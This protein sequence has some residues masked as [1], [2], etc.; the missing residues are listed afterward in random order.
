MRQ[1]PEEKALLDA[2]LGALVATLPAQVVV[3]LVRGPGP[4]VVRVGTQAVFGL[5]VR[6]GWRGQ[7]GDLQLAGDEQVL[8]VPYVGESQGE[9]LRTRGICYLDRVGNAWLTD[10]AG[11]LAVLVQ[12]RA[13]P[14][15]TAS[16]VG[17]LLLGKPGLRLVHALL[18]EPELVRA[19]Y[20]T[21]AAR[22]GLPV[23]TIGRAMLALHGQGFVR[24][25]T[26]RWLARPDELR[27]RWIDAYGETL[28]P[29]LAAGRYRWLE[30]ARA[31][32]GWQEVALP[33][34][35]RWGGETAAHLLLDGYL[36]P[37]YFTLYSTARRGELMGALRLVPDPQGKVEVLI[38]FDESEMG[39]VQPG[40]VSPL[41]AYADLVLS[42]DARN[43]EVAQ[44]LAKEYLKG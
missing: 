22:V 13:R 32:Q 36:L 12:G 31:R 42:G 25:E 15:V 3:K 28:R 8:V 19:P 37:E 29:K 4:A 27:R 6:P 40:C 16:A 39:I 18:L 2:A 7:V 21:V 35:T 34:G 5:V 38:P 33:A 14:A 9:Q 10:A 44:M 24:N 26:R 43:M 11:T 20:R 41:L 1:T 30:P 17:G 23:A